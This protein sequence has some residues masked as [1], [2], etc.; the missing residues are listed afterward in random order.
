MENC[1]DALQKGVS[2]VIIGNPTV[3]LNKQQLFTTLTL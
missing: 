1:F 3:I 2:K